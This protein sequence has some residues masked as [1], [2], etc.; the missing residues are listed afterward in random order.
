VAAERGK[1]PL[2]VKY[3]V[4]LELDDNDTILVSFPDFPEAHTF[5]DDRTDALARAVDALATIVDT[6]MA[7]RRPLPMPSP[8]VKD[9]V[10][11][12]ALM[13]TKA[14]IYQAMVAAGVS[15][16]EMARRLNVH[17]PQVDRLLQLWHGSKI[18]QLESAALALGGTLEMRFVVPVKIAS[19]RDR[20]K[21]TR[22]RLGASTSMLASRTRTGQPATAKKR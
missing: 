6:Y 16:S 15:K 14:E 13:S 20:P 21:V 12:S 18:D 17:L 19:A 7:D 5:G 22:T 1:E 3:P 11:L 2:V 4:I 8:I 9:S 10:A